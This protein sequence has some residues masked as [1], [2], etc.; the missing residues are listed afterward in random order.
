MRSVFTTTMIVLMASAGLA[1]ARP[2]VEMSAPT[3]QSTGPH[4]PSDPD[5]RD[6]VK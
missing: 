5:T 4:T 2:A 3:L 1:T 6:E